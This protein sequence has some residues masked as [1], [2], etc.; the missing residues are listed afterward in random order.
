M[1]NQQQFNMYEME[2]GHNYFKLITTKGEK[3]KLKED[4][5]DLRGSRAFEIEKCKHNEN[6]I[7]CKLDNTGAVVVVDG[8][9]TLGFTL[10]NQFEIDEN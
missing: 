1:K 2:P 10:G 3:F 9:H 5:Y 4:D 7:E 8:H 6:P